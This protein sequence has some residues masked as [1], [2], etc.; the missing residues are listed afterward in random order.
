MMGKKILC[1]IGKKLRQASGKC[2][3]LF[4]GITVILVDGF[5]QL[6]P[7][8]ETEVYVPYDSPG[9]LAY[10]VFK[11]FSTCMRFIAMPVKNIKINIFSKY[12]PDA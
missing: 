12:C 10:I 1:Q 7:V 2:S 4:G 5:Q 11:I 8:F 3:E 9:T 6:P